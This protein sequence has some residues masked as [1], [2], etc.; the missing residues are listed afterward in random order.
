MLKLEINFGNI[1]NFFEIFRIPIKNELLV[2][3]KIID[4]F[5]EKKIKNLP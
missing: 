1:M 5:I 3:K 4:E 2:K